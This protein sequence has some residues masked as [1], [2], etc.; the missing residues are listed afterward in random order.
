MSWTSVGLADAGGEEVSG[1]SMLGG[2][3]YSGSIGDVV[4]VLVSC[5]NTATGDGDFSELGTVT[6][7]AGNSFTKVKEWTNGQGSAAGGATVAAFYGE[8]THAAI[9]ARITVNFANTITAKVFTSWRFTKGSGNV[10][11]VAGSVQTEVVDNGDA[12]NLT[13]SGLPSFE[14]LFIRVIA[15]ETDGAGIA[16]NT[17]SY[18]NI[19]PNPSGTGGSEKGHMSIQ[20]EFRILTGTGD[21]SNPTLT[22][23]TVDLASVYFALNEAAPPVASIPTTKQYR[24]AARRAAYW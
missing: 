22:D 2:N 7:S 23:I 14:Y 10:V 3:P 11:S 8:L 6:D 9:N 20:G 12:G 19:T 24:Q 5:N 1:N 16:T 15:S 13:I 21:S 18:T 17:T 4:V